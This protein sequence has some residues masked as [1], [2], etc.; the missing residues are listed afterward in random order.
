MRRFPA[1]L[2]LLLAASQLAGCVAAVAVPL[3]AGGMVARKE[4]RRGSAARARQVTPTPAPAPTPA[5]GNAPF[6]DPR[7]EI[8]ESPTPLQT[9]GP[10]DGMR[11]L[12]GSGEAAA[13]SLQ[14]YQSLW[15]YLTERVTDRILKRQ[16]ASVVLSSG[17]TLAAPRFESCG[18]K[19]LAA[20]FDIDETAVLNLGYEADDARRGSPGY[21]AERWKRWEQTGTEKLAAVP[22]AVEAVEAA[23][24]AGIVVVFNSNRSEANAAETI[25]A[26]QFA[27]FGLAEPGKTLWLRGEGADS[28][29]DARRWQ[30]AAQYCVIAL[31]GDQ[32]GDFSDLFNPAGTP[33]PVRRNM[34]SETMIAPLWGSGWFI[35][36]N[37][38]YGTG[39]AGGFDDIFPQDKRWTDP[40]EEQR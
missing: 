35:L 13:L 11:F 20:V 14:A 17:S 8:M 10:P 16:I 18:D 28:G 33:V 38:V 2:T 29:K 9:V 15:H 32:L 26:L 31:V 12:Y 5:P 19:P 37:P 4:L 22:G 30:I 21:D 24:R 23:R 3:A 7:A 36:P 39:L 6:V 25:A 1:L 40:A 34:A 27:G